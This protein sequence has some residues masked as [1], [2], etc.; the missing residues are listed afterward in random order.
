MV[1]LRRIDY[2]PKSWEERNAERLKNAFDNHQIIRDRGAFSVAPDDEYN[3]AMKSEKLA[4]RINALKQQTAQQR[5]INRNAQLASAPITI[6]R[7]SLSTQGSPVATPGGWNNIPSPP[8][9]NFGALVAAIAGKES[10]GN[11]GAVNPDSGA[12]GKYQIMP[13]NIASW[14]KAALGYSITP[15]Q[16]LASPR[17]QEQIA[18]H[19]LRQYFNQYGAAGAASAWYSGD[20]NKWK[21]G[22]GHGSQGAYP[23]IYNY[24]MAILKAMGKR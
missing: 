5:A 14:S 24:V 11:Y 10:G 16:F 9:G 17:L 21:T 2:T 22:A 7:P 18:R 13:A 12:L 3:W 20:P 1:M 15:Q 6:R 8:K 19:R 23:T 4:S